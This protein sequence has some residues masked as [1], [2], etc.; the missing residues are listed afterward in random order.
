MGDNSSRPARADGSIV[1]E[2]ASYLHSAGHTAGDG[3]SL[4]VND[5]LDVGSEVDGC[6]RAYDV[7][8]LVAVVPV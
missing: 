3:I 6:V 2:F 1:D 4:A 8:V 7:G 5:V